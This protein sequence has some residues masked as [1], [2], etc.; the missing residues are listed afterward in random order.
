V[1]ELTGGTARLVRPADDQHRGA[2][3]MLAAQ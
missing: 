1:V 2:R 3:P